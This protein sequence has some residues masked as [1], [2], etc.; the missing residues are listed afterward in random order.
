MTPEEFV[1]KL[2]ELQA[3]LRREMP[4][5]YLSTACYHL[6][7]DECRRTCKFCRTVCR[8]PCHRPRTGL[9]SE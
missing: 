8:C 9:S 1:A 7:H 6:V 2:R 5:E 4:H 3:G